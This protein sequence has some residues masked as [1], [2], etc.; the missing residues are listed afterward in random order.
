VDTTAPTE[1]VADFAR[2]SVDQAQ[3]AFDTASDIA[4]SNLQNFDAIAGAFKACSTDI[5]LKAM[6]I[7]QI[8]MNSAFTFVRKACA[9]KEPS[10]L[11]SLSQGYF[12][13]QFAVFTRQTKE[14]SELSMVLATETAKPVQEGLMKSFTNLTKSAA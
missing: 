9:V 13:D 1:E 2:K 12:T 11:F 3:A 6:E 14:M 10:E 8:N 4:H 7:A 5:H